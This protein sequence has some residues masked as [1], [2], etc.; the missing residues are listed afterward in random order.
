MAIIVGKQWYNLAKKPYDRY[1]SKASGS[2]PTLT[3]S[4]RYLYRHESDEGSCIAFYR[5]GVY[6]VLFI[7]DCK[8]RSVGGWSNFRCSLL[9]Y[10]EDGLSYHVNDNEDDSTGDLIITDKQLETH[11]RIGNCKYFPNGFWQTRAWRQFENAYASQGAMQTCTN[12]YNT[13]ITGVAEL[14]APDLYEGMVI[15]I[16]GKYI[17]AMDKYR[18]DAT[19]K[20]F[21]FSPTYSGY[22]LWFGASEGREYLWTTTQGPTYQYGV[23]QAYVNT[24]TQNRNGVLAPVKEIRYGEWRYY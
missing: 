24:Y 1:P 21:C 17:D 9:S 12:F 16:E 5:F 8:Y 4:G 23:A 2:T 13:S 18:N 14:T 11:G 10:G 7:P 15:R 3:P 20:K 19:Y 6:V 22:S